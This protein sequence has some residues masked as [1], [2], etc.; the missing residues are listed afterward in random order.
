[1]RAYLATTGTL[2]GLITVAHVWRVL[3]ES[4]ALARDP[5]FLL[6][7]LVAAGLGAWAFRLLRAGAAPRGRGSDGMS[8]G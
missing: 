2:F 1:M 8:G 4:R 5:W 3:V 7:T 6:A